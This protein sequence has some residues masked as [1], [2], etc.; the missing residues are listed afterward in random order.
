MSICG[1]WRENKNYILKI[2]AFL[3]AYFFSAPDLGDALEL[4]QPYT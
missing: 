3:Y 1:L 4:P 2:S